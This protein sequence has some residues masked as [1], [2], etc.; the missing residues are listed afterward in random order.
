MLTTTDKEATEFKDPTE[1]LG[2]AEM[3]GGNDPNGG[4]AEPGPSAIKSSGFGG[5]GLEGMV[6][7]DEPVLGTT[8]PGDGNKGAI[9]GESS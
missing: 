4:N 7:T 6:G 5:L 3:E 9:S 8:P 1:V 2:D